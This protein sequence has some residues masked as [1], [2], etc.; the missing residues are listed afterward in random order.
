MKDTLRLSK[1]KLQSSPGSHVSA[2]SAGHVEAVWIKRAERAPMDAVSSAQLASNH[3]LL[4][5]AERGGR[6]L[7]MSAMALAD[8]RGKILRIGSARMQIGGETKP[9]ER[10]D[11]VIPGLRAAMYSNWRGGVYARVIADGESKLGDSIEW[12]LT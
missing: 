11:E 10:M 7:S 3:G 4:G 6:N 8:S 9:R 1:A 12:E 2:A 5:S